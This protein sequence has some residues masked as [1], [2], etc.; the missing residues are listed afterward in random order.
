MALPR[1]LP[2]NSGGNHEGLA[3]G[4]WVIPFRGFPF[5][6]SRWGKLPRK[7]PRF[8]LT[9]FQDN[10]SEAPHKVVLGYE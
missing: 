4:V 1:K 10:R 3:K 9:F 6:Q 7:F 5:G 8:L 2:S